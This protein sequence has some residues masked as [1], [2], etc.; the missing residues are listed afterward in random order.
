MT[1]T[2]DE[3][4]DYIG[5][6]RK[7]NQAHWLLSMGGFFGATMSV[8]INQS[9]WWGVLHFFFGW[10]YV[11]YAFTVRHESAVAGIRR[12]LDFFK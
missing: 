11:L 8:L 7:R 1:D 9:F 5:A 2:K 3:I 6:V 12:L 10:Y 4:A